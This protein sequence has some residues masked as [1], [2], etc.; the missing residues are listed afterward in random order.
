VI[1]K[2]GLQAEI[3]AITAAIDKHSAS[4]V[5]IDSFKAVNELPESVSAFRQFAYMLRVE[6][7]AWHCTFFSR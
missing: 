4:I 1:H 2:N 6:L 7:I 5:A 3:E